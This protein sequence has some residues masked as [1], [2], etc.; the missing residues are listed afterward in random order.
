VHSCLSEIFISELKTG[1]AYLCLILHDF[2]VS[3]VIDRTTWRL[4]R[5]A[6]KP[7]LF[8]CT[9]TGKVAAG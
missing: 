3:H 9:K 8:G 5:N 1:I 7:T 6:N 2:G 4:D